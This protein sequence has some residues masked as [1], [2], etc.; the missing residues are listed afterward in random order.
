MHTGAHSTRTH[1]PSEWEHRGETAR[2]PYCC[3]GSMGLAVTT[4]PAGYGLDG[5]AMVLFSHTKPHHGVT[6]FIIFYTNKTPPKP[7]Q[8][9]HQQNTPKTKPT[10]TPTKHPQNQTNIEYSRRSR[11]GRP[12][13]VLGRPAHKPQCT[14]THTAP[15]QVTVPRG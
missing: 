6:L 5:S 3:D 1:K 11:G 9:I 15:Y 12:R 4:A 2:T 7:N 8:R 13:R 10:H 14:H